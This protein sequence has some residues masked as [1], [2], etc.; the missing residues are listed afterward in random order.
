MMKPKRHLLV[1]VL[2]FIGG[3]AS[4]ETGKCGHAVTVTGDSV[5]VTSDEVPIAGSRMVK[6]GKPGIKPELLQEAKRIIHILDELQLTDCKDIPIALS[7][8]ARKAYE[9]RRHDTFQVLA[10]LLKDLEKTD[11]NDV[12]QQRLRDADL[13]AEHLAGLL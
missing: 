5:K 2:V 1:S 11:T 6:I 4:I 7:A 9:V 13:K 10:D 8:E 3:C 12:Y